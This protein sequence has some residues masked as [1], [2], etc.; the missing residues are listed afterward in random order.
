MQTISVHRTQLKAQR[1]LILYGSNLFH[2]YR[3]ISFFYTA[4]GRQ[5]CAKCCS[6]FMSFRAMDFIFIGWIGNDYNFCWVARNFDFERA[7]EIFSKKSVIFYFFK[8]Y[9]FRR[10]DSKPET[11]RKIWAN[12]PIRFWN[13]RPH[14]ENFIFLWYQPTKQKNLCV[15]ITS[16]LCKFLLFVLFLCWFYF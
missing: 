11:P 4:R 10:Y 3:S 16:T 15:R 13:P 2:L 12:Q 7:N 1:F 8:K 14:F 9:I 6:N 5:K